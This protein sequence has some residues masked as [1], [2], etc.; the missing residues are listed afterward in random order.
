MRI[1]PKANSWNPYTLP[2]A[3]GIFSRAFET[4]L[5]RKHVWCGNMLVSAMFL[6]RTQSE[7][8]QR[9]LVRAGT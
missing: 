3:W 5:D 4:V 2:R 8:K 1:L 6:G 9:L 7:V